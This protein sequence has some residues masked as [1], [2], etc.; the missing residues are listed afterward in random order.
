MKKA[1]TTLALCCAAASV[2]AAEFGND[3][4]VR[5][6]RIVYEKSFTEAE[7]ERIKP[8]IVAAMNQVAEFYGERKGATP[9]FFFCKSAECARYM[10]GT[11]WRSVTINKGGRRN[12]DGKYWF[13]RPSIV[14]TEWARNPKISDKGLQAVLAHEL[15]HVELYARGAG[16]DKVPAW[17]NE[18]LATV[19]GG[20]NCKPGVRGID[21]LS[22]LSVGENWRNYTRPS[23]GHHGATYCQAGLEVLA[24]AE[25]HGG[26]KGIV[27][28]VANLPNKSFESQY[29]A[30]VTP[31]GATANI[32]D[33]G[34]K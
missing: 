12:D 28:L 13:E 11:E 1:L 9:D 30:F 7:Q 34:E 14:I 3:D 20:A 22:K 17:F 15:S 23:G 10:F 26:A 29:G 21:D 19:V 6:G 25:Q 4:L 33:V 8:L 32:K 27:D 24:W 2:S 31:Q 16:H 18:G 5:Q